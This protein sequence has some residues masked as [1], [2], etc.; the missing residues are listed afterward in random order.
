MYDSCLKLPV[1]FTNLHFPLHT[2]REKYGKNILGIRSSVYHTDIQDAE[3]RCKGQSRCQFRTRSAI[4][5]LRFSYE[6]RIGVLN[7]Q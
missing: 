5:I 2:L 4:P 7:F 6:G 3:N 1:V